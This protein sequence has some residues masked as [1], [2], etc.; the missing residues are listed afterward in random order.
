MWNVRLDIFWET[1]STFINP[2]I[3]TFLTQNP[4][5]KGVYIAQWRQ[6]AD[7]SEEFLKIC[8]YIY[9]IYGS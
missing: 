7:N 1:L 6:F 5:D 9:G 2:R 8:S 3:S 4:V